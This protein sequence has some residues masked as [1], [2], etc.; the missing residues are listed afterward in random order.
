MIIL[1]SLHSFVENNS[2]KKGGKNIN[3][4]YCNML[5][6]SIV[7]REENGDESRNS[8]EI[9]KTIKAFHLMISA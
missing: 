5:T 7:L 4:S 8:E 3:Q 2:G 6:A 1:I 9:E